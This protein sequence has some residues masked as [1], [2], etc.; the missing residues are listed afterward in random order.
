M[1]AYNFPSNRQRVS[2]DFSNTTGSALLKCFVLLTAS[3]HF[4]KVEGDFLL[5]GDTV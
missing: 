5:V 2:T 3:S 4:R 1:S